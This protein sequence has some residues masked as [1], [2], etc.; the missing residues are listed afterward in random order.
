MS[1][2]TPVGRPVAV[3]RR[4]PLHILKDLGQIALIVF[5]L[6]VIL[7]PIYWMITTALKSGVDTFAVP[8]K[9]IFTPTMDH[10][11]AI[12]EE[13]A[14][15]PSLRNSII[16]ATASTF[17]AVLLG[18][19]AA[20]VLARFEFRFKPDLWFWIISNR[21]I[22]PIVVALPFFLIARDLQLLDKHL[23][24]ILVYLTFGV[25]LVVW[26]CVDQFKAI[27]REID[28][29]AFV[30]GA[31]LWQVFFRMN[32]PL[33]A[34]GIAVSAILVFINCWNELMFALVLTRANARTAPVEAANFMTG[35]GIRWGPMMAT[36]ALIVLPVLIF[37]ILVS[38]NLVRGLTMG[39]VK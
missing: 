10:F 18:A 13:G 3:R 5:I 22:S 23:G 9:L 8:P 1:T 24:L 16:V 34:P 39:A 38:R 27:P 26:L 36:G 25:P 7:L 11:E 29:A 19:P 12:W 6:L 4:R 21:F 20:Y 14:V 17:L 2:T 30:D 32:L 35:F 37:A 31:N 33:A 15:L 28:E